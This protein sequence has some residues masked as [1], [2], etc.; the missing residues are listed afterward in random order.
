MP[1]VW[2][3]STQKSEALKKPIILL[4]LVL[5]PAFRKTTDVTV[6]LPETFGIMAVFPGG[7]LIAV[8]N[9]PPVFGN[10]KPVAG[11]GYPPAMPDISWPLVHID[12]NIVMVQIEIAPGAG[13]ET[14]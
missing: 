11:L 2:K 14:E 6:E 8:G 4:A 13:G 12:V 9:T 3:L 1:C 7:R 5:A 10:M